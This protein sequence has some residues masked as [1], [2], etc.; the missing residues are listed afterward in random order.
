MATMMSGETEPSSGIDHAEE[1][2][3]TEGH[4]DEIHSM[5]ADCESGPHAR[6][7][8]PIVQTI[9]LSSGMMDI[10]GEEDTGTFLNDKGEPVHFVV[11][12]GHQCEHCQQFFQTS[13]S[14]ESESYGWSLIPLACRIVC[15]SNSPR[16]QLLQ[17]YNALDLFS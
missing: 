11:L 5:E 9:M 16:V 10:T 12:P 14:L 1:V 7:S 13:S 3:G 15:I 4:N 8:S 6:A 2:M 17:A